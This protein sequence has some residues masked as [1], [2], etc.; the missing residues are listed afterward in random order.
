M[1]KKKKCSNP[2][3]QY[4]PC[5]TRKRGEWCEREEVGKEGERE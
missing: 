3:N 1:E 2:C 5:V 4:S